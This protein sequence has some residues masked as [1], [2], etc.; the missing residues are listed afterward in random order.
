MSLGYT[1]FNRFRIPI[2]WIWATNCSCIKTSDLNITRNGNWIYITRMC[3]RE[4]N[5]SPHISISF[6]QSFRNIINLLLQY[7]IEK[8]QSKCMIITKSPAFEFIKINQTVCVAKYVY[9]FK[10]NSNMNRMISY[11]HA[12][13]YNSIQ[14]CIQILTRIN[15]VS[16]AK[17]NE[18]V[19]SRATFVWLILI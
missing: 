15:F 3:M 17:N 14:M 9:T 4:M 2:V 1:F 10:V 16:L 6:R 11:E 5:H 12:V 19:H 18:I 7:R 8:R 13:E